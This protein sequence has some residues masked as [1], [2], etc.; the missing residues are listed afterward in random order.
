MRNAALGS[1]VL[2][3]VAA[4]DS[5]PPPAPERRGAPP[6]PAA[7]A[8]ASAAGSA[9]AKADCSRTEID[10]PKT[11]AYFPAQSEGLCLDPKQPGTSFGAEARKPLEGVCDLFDGECQVYF[12][13]GVRRVVELGYVDASGKPASVGV[14]ASEFDAP[15][16]A[17]A[18]FTKRTVGDA[19]PAVPTS[20]PLEV[21]G[22]AG[23]AIGIGNAYLVKGSFLVEL[24]YNDDA[25]SE[26]E[27]RAAGERLLPALAAAITRAL[28]GDGALPPAVALLPSEHRLPLG[29]R[30]VLK[31]ALG[32]KGGGPMAMSYHRDGE[33]RYRVLAAVHADEAAAKAAFAA[34]SALGGE[35]LRDLGDEAVRVTLVEGPLEAELVLARKGPRLAGVVDELRVLR[36]G[37]TPEERGKIT[38]ASEA[39]RERLGAELLR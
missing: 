6:P 34:F 27:L 7:T 18:M 24:T 8:Q 20:K 28:P 10:D 33:R 22:A 36:T 29:V 2:L 16:S 17:Y 30:S 5:N 39:K 19:D 13:L 35:K 38:I 9:A 25:A 11:K 12:D 37:M 14:I 1:L 31:D 23:A 32:V 15:A 21:P 26:P 3:V 4:C